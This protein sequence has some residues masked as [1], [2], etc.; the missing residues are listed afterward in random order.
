[1]S[2]RAEPVLRF[3]NTRRLWSLLRSILSSGL[4]RNGGQCCDCE[5]SRLLVG[6]RSICG[7]LKSFLESCSRNLSL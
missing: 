1:M 3:N 7:L 4:C 5:R 2:L 6:N